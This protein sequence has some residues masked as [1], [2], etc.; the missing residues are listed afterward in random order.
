MEKNRLIIPAAILLACFALWIIFYINKINKKDL[1]KEED[2]HQ[3]IQEFPWRKET[4]SPSDG[5]DVDYDYNY[6]FDSDVDSDPDNNN[7]D[8]EFNFDYDLNPPKDQQETSQ[9]LPGIGKIDLLQEKVNNCLLLEGQRYQH[10]LDIY[11]N[12][13]SSNYIGDDYFLE[14]W[15][16]C[17]KEHERRK[18][19]CYFSN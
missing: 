15:K 5:Y 17:E 1:D 12:R 13:E 11:L 16:L 14:Y 8:Y 18:T 2:S 3:E 7:P 4:R 6:D 19:N 10:T 9:T